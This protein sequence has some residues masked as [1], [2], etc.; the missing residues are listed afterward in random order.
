MFR[1]SGLLLIFLS[2]F[3]QFYKSTVKNRLNINFINDTV[4]LLQH[5]QLNVN[6]GKSYPEIIKNNSY[7]IYKNFD[8]Y[9]REIL[10]NS[11]LKSKLLKKDTVDIVFNIFSSLGKNSV[12]EETIYINR[13]LKQLK[14]KMKELKD[15]YNRNKKANLTAG[16]SAGLIVVILLI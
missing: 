10:Y 9:N 4:N 2:V 15:E 13:Q 1:I 3:M 12:Y 5:I 14:E 7:G 16:I 11:L 6:S 8:F